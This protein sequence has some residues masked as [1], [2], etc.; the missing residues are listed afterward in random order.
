MVERFNRTVKAMLSMFVAE[1]QDD[2]DEHLPYVMMAYRSSQH[3]AIKFTPNLLMLGR[4][5]GLP[6]DV[7][8]GSP[9]EQTET[10]EALDYVD[11]LRGRLARAHEFARQH[12]RKAQSYQKQQY[13][14]RAQGAGF[15]PGQA[16]WPPVKPTGA[17]PSC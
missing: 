10:T 4:E 9:E 12:L 6:L 16:V 8:V 14:R 5:V 3:D 2:W 13:D 11:G 17:A 7:V 15:E 1:N